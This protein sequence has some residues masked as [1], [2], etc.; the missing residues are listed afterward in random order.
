MSSFT[1][2]PIC[3]FRARS[4]PAVGVQATATT[5]APAAAATPPGNNNVPILVVQDITACLAAGTSAQGPI[6]VNL[7]DGT[8]GG[9]NVAWSGIVGALANTSTALSMS[10]LNI[11]CKSGF[12][13]LEFAAAGGTLASESVA[14]GGYYA[15]GM[16]G[17]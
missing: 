12:A 3:D 4:V 14:F 11:P 17:Q 6:T 9:T 13:T 2:N 15:G 16:G 10:Y 1:K 8:S 7:I 5:T